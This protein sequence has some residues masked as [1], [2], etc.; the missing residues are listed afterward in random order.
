MSLY[1]VLV[2]CS[3]CPGNFSCL[4]EIG[5]N[6]NFGFTS[7]DNFGWALLC[8]YRLM[9]QDYWEN[10]YMLVRFH[11][12]TFVCIYNR[13]PSRNEFRINGVSKRNDLK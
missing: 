3:Q 9:T 7:F 10:L 2:S 1:D 11:H 12:I 5:D 6:P 8:A 4:R 13:S